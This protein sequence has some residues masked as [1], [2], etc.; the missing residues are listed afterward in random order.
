MDKNRK[1][2]PGLRKI[3]EEVIACQK[4]PLAEY[5]RKNK[6][7]PVVGEGSHWAKIMFIGEAPGLEEA[8]RGRPFCGR[9]GKVLDKL[10]AGAGIKRE[11]VYITNVLKDRPPN[12]RDPKEE[13]IKAC[14]PYLER[15][16][17][18]IEPE[19][20]CTLGNYATK[21]IFLTYKNEEPPGISKIHGKVFL[22]EKF[23]ILPLYHPAVAV[24][25]SNMEAVLEKDFENLKKLLQ[26]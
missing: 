19:I 8:K 23:K 7:L 18:L 22:S 16:I 4:C 12:N 24:Y 10:L 1:V 3:K 20:I 2:K 9:A 25:N 15:Q 21:Y 13:E 26:A 6:F 11:D 17:K 5:R 14:A